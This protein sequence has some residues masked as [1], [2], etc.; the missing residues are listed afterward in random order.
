MACS[1]CGWVGCLSPAYVRTFIP[2]TG[3]IQDAVAFDPKQGLGPGSR[4]VTSAPKSL[5]W[6]GWS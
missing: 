3:P 5:F 4:A 1:F 2:A 6:W